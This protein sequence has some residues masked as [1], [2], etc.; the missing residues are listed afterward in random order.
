MAEEVKG[1]E[2]L[3]VYKQLINMGFKEH[4]TLQAARK[5]SNVKDAIEWISRNSNDDG[6]VNIRARGMAKD[7]NGIIIY[8]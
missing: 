7:G 2:Y 8:L 5:Y 1:E 4:I 3:T 6:N